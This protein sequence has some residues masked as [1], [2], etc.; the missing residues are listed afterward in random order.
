MFR[1]RGSVTMNAKEG[2]PIRP[3]RNGGTVGSAQ[4]LI[5]KGMDESPHSNILMSVLI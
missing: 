1:K 2:R 3:L 5:R 4:S